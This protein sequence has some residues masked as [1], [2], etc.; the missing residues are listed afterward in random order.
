MLGSGQPPLTYKG[1]L[2]L[3]GK[4]ETIPHASFKAVL[5]RSFPT[6]QQVSLML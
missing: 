3:A 2:Q 6:M 4:C 5:T 1:A